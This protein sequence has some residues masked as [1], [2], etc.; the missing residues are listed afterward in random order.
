VRGAPE[1]R[2][3]SAEM[4]FMRRILEHKSNRIIEELQILQIIRIY[5]IKQ[6]MLDR[7]Y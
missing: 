1:R 4:F 7:A 5:E 2:L 3:M 6:I